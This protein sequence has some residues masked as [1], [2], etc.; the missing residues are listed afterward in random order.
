M[1][2]LFRIWVVFAIFALVGCGAGGSSGGGGG[3]A[4]APSASSDG[5]LSDEQLKKM[6][7]SETYGKRN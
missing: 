4:A 7:I 3:G 6:G 1:N 5:G 2:I